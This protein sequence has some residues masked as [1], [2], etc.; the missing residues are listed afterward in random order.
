MAE[1]DPDIAALIEESFGKEPSLSQK[2]IGGTGRVLSPIASILDSLDTGLNTTVNALRPLVEQANPALREVYENAPIKHGIPNV[3]FSDL[4]EAGIPKGNKIQNAARATAGFMLDVA[5]DPLTY[6]SG[7]GVLTKAGRVTKAVQGA[8]K[9]KTAISVTSPIG[10]EALKIVG[11]T[12]ASGIKKA[13]KTLQLGENL[14]EQ[15]EKH[16]RAL[17]SIGIPFT[18]IDHPLVY[19]SKVFS[20]ADT[21]SKNIKA[22]KFGKAFFQVFSTSSGNPLFD[23]FRN[24]MVSLGRHLTGQYK[25]DAT[26][27]GV[28][29]EAIRKN[30]GKSA[31]ELKRELIDLVENPEHGNI[32]A[33]SVLENNAPTL[34][35]TLYKD[36]KE[37]ETAFK[38]MQGIQS[39]SHQ[40]RGKLFRMM[41]RDLSDT[42]SFGNPYTIGFRQLPEEIRSTFANLTVSQSGMPILQAGGKTYKYANFGDVLKAYTRGGKYNGKK[43][44]SEDSAL[45]ALVGKKEFKRLT[46]I[47]KKAE[48]AIQINKQSG[49]P[50]PPGVQKLIQAANESA[51]MRTTVRQMLAHVD[52]SFA[53]NYTMFRSNPQMLQQLNPKAHKILTQIEKSH[54]WKIDSLIKQFKFPKE[55]AQ[56]YPELYTFAQEIRRWLRVLH[57]EEEFAGV[58][59]SEWVGDIFYAPHIPTK[60]VREFFEKELGYKGAGRKW[61]INHVNQLKRSLG[62]VNSGR[63][64][65]AFNLGL[66]SAG[67]R[68][69]LLGPN[70]MKYIEDK[71]ASKGKDKWSQEFGTRFIK[72]L[73]V[74]QTNA[75]A[76]KP[77]D[78]LKILNGRT[79]EKF[80]DDNPM[81]LLRIRGQRGAKAIS[82]A[83]FFEA[84]K[85]LGKAVPATSPIAPEGLQFVRGGPL[86]EVARDGTRLA[87]D[88][89]VAK[90]L[91]A[92]YDELQFPVAAHPFIETFDKL[93]DYWKA[94]TL[95][96]FVTYHLRNVIGN[97]WNNQLAGLRDPKYYGMALN[98]QHI[99]GGTAEQALKFGRVGKKIVKFGKEKGISFQPSN[100]V[101]K[102][103]AGQKYTAKEIDQLARENGIINI[104]QYEGDILKYFEAEAKSA[105]SR[106]FRYIP[107]AGLKVG[108]YFEN[109]AKLAHFIWQLENGMSASDAAASVKKYLFDYTDLTDVERSVFRRVLPFY[110]WTR[111]NVPLQLEALITAPNKP[112]GVNKAIGSFV[113]TNYDGVPDER[114]LPDW[115]VQ[116]YPVRVRKASS[117]NF[118]YFL[119]G[120][121]LPLADIDKIFN[122]VRHVLNMLT[123][124]LKEPIQQAANRDF[125]FGREI[126][127]T[128][129]LT[130]LGDE[131]EKFAGINMPKRLSHIGRNIRI[132]TEADRAF[133]TQEGVDNVTKIIRGVLGK[134]YPYD[135]ELQRQ[136]NTKE[137]KRRESQLKSLLKK[138]I[139]KGNVQE[140]DRLRKRIE[141]LVEEAANKV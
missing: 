46:G 115:M 75:L 106:G 104:G 19:G 39:L 128:A 49:K 17:I 13:K 92:Y 127:P 56:K 58:P 64:E 34:T 54:D 107:D 80:F 32:S 40:E 82:S 119:L 27:F 15:A 96:P 77:V 70:G 26:E 72:Y 53:L 88:P 55:M 136:F 7:I 43:L 69:V 131:Y 71:I 3:T 22:N 9:A 100:F 89:D 141:Q 65:E 16:Q 138:A 12:G 11:G 14:A 8:A 81:E 102:T 125:Y 85:A 50:F 2:V 60:E 61:T 132:V 135:E 78:G 105:I 42:Q 121:W 6:L 109:N 118:E 79:F 33:I 29:F 20:T 86:S 139:Q 117:G 126:D 41:W 83:Q 30:S 113:E 45:L 44:S 47:E 74:S 52:E 124:I 97:V 137:F 51:A 91:D 112:M 35:Q 87:F 93:Q 48:E 90:H 108:N 23:K 59:T 122:P 110:T 111:K 67:E 5:A 31:E 1:I 114:N 84:S 28:K 62:N 94:W 24:D 99:A 101:L 133:S 120:S 95:A 140:E 4:L 73:T 134:V 18:G 123:P 21:I 38:N 116:Q 130:T 25:M 129:T 76:R 66:I 37:F 98:V 103:K 57:K 68:K 10:K 63:V 36:R